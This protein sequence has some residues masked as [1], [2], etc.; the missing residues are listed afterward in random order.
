MEII[1]GE[2]CLLNPGVL[3]RV[4]RSNSCQSVGMNT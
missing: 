1:K 4:Q 3:E 2:P